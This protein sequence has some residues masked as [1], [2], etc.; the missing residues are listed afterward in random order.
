MEESTKKKIHSIEIMVA[1]VLL[2]VSILSFFPNSGITGFVSLETKTQEI[3]LTIAN[4][5]SYILTTGRKEPFYMT[6]LK[7][8]GEVIGEGI[9]KAYMDNGQGERI[10]IYSNVVK[11][12]KGAVA[13]TG[14]HGISGNAVS[15]D[16]EIEGSETEEEDY[17]LIDY[18]ENIEEELGEIAEDEKTVSGKF[19]YQCIDSCFID[20]MLSEDLGYQLLF[21]VEEGTILKINEI[22]YGVRID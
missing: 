9:V 3:N 8:S 12:G 6:S 10:L 16:S 11:K 14:M 22:V 18:L 15:V 21:Y 20:M 17:L 1:V 7:L 13:I 5:Q 19:K 2:L 4:S